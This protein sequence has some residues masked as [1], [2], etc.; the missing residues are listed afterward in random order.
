MLFS[1]SA[2]S[3]SDSLCLFTP[4]YVSSYL[5][6][7]A[8][9]TGCMLWRPFV[10]KFVNTTSFRWRQ[11]R[12]KRLENWPHFPLALWANSAPS[13][14]VFKPDYRQ[15]NAPAVLGI[16]LW[17]A[18]TW[19]SYT[20]YQRWAVCKQVPQTWNPQMCGL[21]NNLLDLRTLRKCHT[22]RICNLRTKSFSDLLT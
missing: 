19:P 15:D 18:F 10:T 20:K 9:F 13:F 17:P 16:H 21:K 14:S 5:A 12:R 6:V 2:L 4:L 22:L 11:W 1:V 3:T 8:S 7:S